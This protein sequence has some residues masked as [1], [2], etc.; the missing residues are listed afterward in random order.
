MAK[1]KDTKED[2]RKVVARNSK[3]FHEYEI[4]DRLE[5]G[6]VLV[7]T[8]VKRLRASNAVLDGAY[9]KLEIGELWLIN[10]EIPEYEMGNRQNHKPKRTRKLLG[11]RREMD[12]FAG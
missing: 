8:E 1:K 4:L 5:A 9:A 6:M 10:S 2:G 3:A 12:K 7:G 11:H